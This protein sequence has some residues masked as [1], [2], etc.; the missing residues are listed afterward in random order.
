MQDHLAP[1]LSEAPPIQ[2]VSYGGGDPVRMQM[3]I[4]QTRQ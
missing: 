1:L 2:A 3:S 4:V